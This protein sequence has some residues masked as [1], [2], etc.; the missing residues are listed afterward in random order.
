[1]GSPCGNFVTGS[2]NVMINRRPATMTLVATATC[3]DHSGTPPLATGAA[4]VFVNGK[5]AGRIGEKVGCSALSIEPASPNV[6][7]GGPSASD[8]A[9]VVTPEVPAWAVTALQVMGVAGAVMALPYAIATVG[10][11][12]TIGGR[13]RWLYRIRHCDQGRARLGRAHGPV[14]A[15]HPRDGNGGRLPG[16]T[17]GWGACGTGD[18]GVQSALSGLGRS[19][20]AWIERRQYPGHATWTKD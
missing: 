2:P 3:A 8:P 1:M 13:D 9:V 18:P 10:V 5:P 7:I 14:R 19:E 12:A 17:G 11:A 6:M 20:R 4:T 16:R 15:D